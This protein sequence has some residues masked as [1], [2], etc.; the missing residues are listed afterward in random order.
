MTEQYTYFFPRPMVTVDAVV[1]SR[2]QTPRV[3]LVERKHAPF[4]GH[5]ALP[6]GFVDMEEPLDMAVARELHEE[7][8]I[9]GVSFRQLHTF[10]A[11]GRDPRGRTISVAYLGVVEAP[12]PPRGGD[13]AAR[14]AWH[15]AEEPPALA[16]DH[17]DILRMALD[18]A[19]KENLLWK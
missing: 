11:P 9:G 10:G 17:A 18:R 4:A 3:L 1:L 8:G 14:A 2:E 6:G 16:F 15:P 13:D 5:W 12:Q 7:T 19:Q